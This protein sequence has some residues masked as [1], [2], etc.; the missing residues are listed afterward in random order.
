M[1]FRENK[2]PSSS[3]GVE[4]HWKLCVVDDID[5]GKINISNKEVDFTKN[6]DY[7]DITDECAD[8]ISFS[9]R[10]LDFFSERVALERFELNIFGDISP[11]THIGGLLSNITQK[12]SD[13]AVYCI[14]AN[15]EYINNSVYCAF[16][17]GVVD[18]D[19][20]MELEIAVVEIGCDEGPYIIPV[21]IN[22]DSLYYYNFDDIMKLSFWL[23]NFWIG[24]QNKLNN[25]SEDI[26]IIEQK[27][28]QESITI[29]RYKK[30]NRAVLV[31][32]IVYVDNDNSIKGEELNL[33]RK[34]KCPSWGVRGHYRT[35][36]DGRVI[37]VSP[38]KKGRERDNPEAFVKKEYLFDE[39][40]NI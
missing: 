14:Y 1:D 25:Y 4:H 21:V 13:F 34:Y 30:E 38:Y 31:R 3:S 20:G 37:P 35:L 40:D 36:S 27:N 26:R 7:F 33:R 23:G 5:F 22:E 29:D 9:G 2:L 6:V 18:D 12:K 11:D 24:V 10:K 39:Q 28:P 8:L 16:T 17:I 19:A 32:K 15:F